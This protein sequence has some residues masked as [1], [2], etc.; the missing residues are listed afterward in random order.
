[1]K[2]CK[3]HPL[4]PAVYFCDYCNINCCECCI[5]DGV[6]KTSPCCFNCNR[7]VDSYG[8]NFS[9]VPFWRRLEE[10]FRYPI[11]PNTLMLMGVLSVLMALVSFFAE[12]AVWVWIIYVALLGVQLK[13]CF[14][15]LEKTA[16]GDQSAPDI[17]AALSG[18]LILIVKLIMTMIA[19]FAGLSLLNHF[20]GAI[21]AGL[22]GVIMVIGIPAMLINYAL[23]EDI[24]EAINPIKMLGLIT[25]I[26]LPYGLLIGFVVVMMG[27]VSVVNELL[28]QNLSFVS[29]AL[30]SF[31]SSYYMVVVFHIM[32][33][34]IFQYQHQLGFVLDGVTHSPTM[35]KRNAQQLYHAH[36]DIV[37][38]E[39]RYDEAYTLLS[40]ATAR[41]PSD[42]SLYNKLFDLIYYSSNRNMLAR[43]G[44]GYLR[45]L[46]SSGQPDKLYTSYKKIIK[47]DPKFDPEGIELRHRL[48]IACHSMGDSLSVVTLLNGLM[49]KAP[50]YTHLYDAYVLLA[51]ALENI[52]GMEANAEQCRILLERLKSNKERPKLKGIAAQQGKTQFEVKDVSSQL[53]PEKTI[54]VDSRKK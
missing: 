26:G 48:A 45:A 41:F 9:A 3:Y 7:A 1:M 16:S 13:Y 19:L 15:C 24:L 51:Q 18:G 29:L 25:G 17:Y 2:Y 23:N 6:G 49:G 14:E 38:K 5:N 8:I 47:L 12:L 20:L 34:M 10:S 32:G 27:S 31:V 52:P 42:I 54:V 36:I 30:Q 44:L 35:N 33:Y 43:F 37:I 21:V 46:M 28:G 53:E 50:N 22:A 39:G 40:E 4:N 11:N